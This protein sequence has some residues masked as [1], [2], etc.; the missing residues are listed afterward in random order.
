MTLYWHWFCVFLVLQLCLTWKF[1]RS[2]FSI[3][4]FWLSH[5]AYKDALAI[6]W[7]EVKHVIAL[8]YNKL[9]K[10]SPLWW[11]IIWFFI[12]IAFWLHFVQRNRLA[13]TNWRT[14]QSSVR[15]DAMPMWCDGTRMW[16]VDFEP[17]Q[18]NIRE[19][20]KINRFH[21]YFLVCSCFLWSLYLLQHSTKAQLKWQQQQQSNIFH[22]KRGHELMMPISMFRFECW[23][24]QLIVDLTTQNAGFVDNELI[25]NVEPVCR[26]TRFIRSVHRS[27][28]LECGPRSP[29]LTDPV[30]TFQL[31][32]DDRI[33]HMKI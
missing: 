4:F 23:S 7:Y 10:F 14:V 2:I 5:K 29:Y 32:I 8:A 22:D 26:E 28:F 1:I 17:A 3:F 21:Y 20:T 12:N 31:Q 11:Q 16:A 13:C 18:G 6:W 27:N 30:S 24:I 25:S 9:I 19:L 15:Y 33:S